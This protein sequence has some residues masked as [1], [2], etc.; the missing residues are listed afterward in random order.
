[1][2]IIMYFFS[3]YQISHSKL[4]AP[5]ALP[6]PG[7]LAELMPSWHFFWL[8][9]YAIMNTFLK[10]RKVSNKKDT[11]NNP[12]EIDLNK[13]MSYDYIEKSVIKLPKNSIEAM[14][15]YANGLINEQ[16]YGRFHNPKK[17]EDD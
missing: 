15:M 2:G 5:H 17:T 12:T 3:I 11:N 7:S 14:R 13:F 16:M 9:F 8:R 6:R 1:M 4:Q 10:S